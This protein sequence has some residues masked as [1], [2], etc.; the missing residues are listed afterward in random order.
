MFNLKTSIKNTTHPQKNIIN[1]VYKNF[2]G[3][4]GSMM[5]FTVFNIFL[6][7]QPKYTQ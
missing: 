5:Q 7:L 4:E 1:I 3:G 6:K 2:P